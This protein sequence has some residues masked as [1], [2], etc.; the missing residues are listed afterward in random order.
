MDDG[1]EKCNIPNNNTKYTHI[2][3]QYETNTK[4]HIPKHM[5]FFSQNFG[6]NWHELAHIYV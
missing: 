3:T 6:T 4:T 1:D 5:I 2:H